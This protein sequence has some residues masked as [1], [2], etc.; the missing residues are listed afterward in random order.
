[1]TRLSMWITLWKLGISSQFEALFTKNMGENL[2]KS[3]HTDL[4]I[5]K[6]EPD[7]SMTDVIECECVT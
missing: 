3:R 1:M 2:W 7:W 6:N 4:S 5:P